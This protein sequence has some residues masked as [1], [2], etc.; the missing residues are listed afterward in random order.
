MGKL[1][2]GKIYR[3]F[4]DLKHLILVLLL[5]LKYTLKKSETMEFRLDSFEDENKN[6]LTLDT[7]ISLSISKSQVLAHYPL[8]Y[9]KHFPA[10]LYEKV[11]TTVY[12]FCSEGIVK[13]DGSIVADS[14][15]GFR[16][17]L[18]DLEEGQMILDYSGGFCCSCPAM[19]ILTGLQE[20]VHRGDC[21]LLSSDETAHCLEFSDTLFAGYSV[22]DFYYDYEINVDLIYSKKTGET[23][24]N[25]N[26]SD[27]TQES[28]SIDTSSDQN[29]NDKN[30]EEE[31][32]DT[33]TT[34]AQQQKL[35]KEN[36]ENES[37]ETN[38]NDSQT[39]NSDEMEHISETLSINNRM[40][41]NGIL[42]AE[43]VGDFMPIK[44][45]PDLKD[46]IFLRPLPKAL[47]T[48]GSGKVQN[49][50]LVVDQNMVS[51]DGSEC[52]KIGSFFIYSFQKIQIILIIA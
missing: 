48:D 50:W 15:C 30:L 1:L 33:E 3:A 17:D 21:G 38:S 22:G 43:I 2:E 34:T 32:T 23:Q 14:T 40:V 49:D 9:R 29:Q 41:N 26:E 19:T 27:N 45:P 12:P 20:G 36:S 44:S 28:D 47:P 31:K 46:K 35:K 13:S 39:K 16:T 18:A 52:D 25:Q 7:P 4:K 42:I 10:Q 11:M 51:M 8:K 6:V 24:T 37:H 5:Y